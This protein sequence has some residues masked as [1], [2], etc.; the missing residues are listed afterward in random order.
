MEDK[1]FATQFLAVLA[2]L[3]LFTVVILIIANV[4]TGK[5]K[6]IDDPTMKSQVLE[7][8][9][10]VGKVHVGEAPAMQTASTQGSATEKTPEQIY[11]TV[12]A[13]CHT[14]G[15][16]NAPKLGDAAVWKQRL[17]KGLEAVYQNAINGLNAMPARGGAAELSDEQVK[18]AVDYL[19]G[20]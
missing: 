2:G 4:L 13:A 10:P 16:L 6:Y 18:A 12:C 20:R 3:L 5:D 15:V 17:E 11:Q 8:I 19:V 14:A 9:A 7:R 1:Q